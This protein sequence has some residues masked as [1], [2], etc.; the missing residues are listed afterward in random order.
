M[1]FKLNIV[2]ESVGVTNQYIKMHH[3]KS[4]KSVMNSIPSNGYNQILFIYRM[5][6]TDRMQSPARM[7][8]ITAI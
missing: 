4:V 6:W 8:P 5:N 3:V 1:D 2:D 7:Q